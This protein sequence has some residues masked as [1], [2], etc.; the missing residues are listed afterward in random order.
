MRNA[1]KNA[2]QG[3]AARRQECATRGERKALRGR[4]RRTRYVAIS[5]LLWGLLP[6]AHAFEAI[7]DLYWPE[8]GRFPAYPAVTDS[9]TVRFNAYTGVMRDSNVFRLSDTA[10]PVTVLGTGQK[11]DTIFRLG[12]GIDVDLPVSRQ[13]LVLTG[14]VERRDYDQFDL[15]DHTAYQLGGV[16]RWVVGNDWSGDIGYERRK[17]LEGFGEIQAPLKDM[18]TADHAYA[19][20]G[21]LLTPR[22]RVRGGLEW[23]KFDHSHPTQS[24]VDLE[25]SSVV[26]GLDYMTPAMNSIGGQLRYTNGNYPN[27][28]L[29]GVGLVD[30]SYKE[31]ELSAVLHWVLTG[32]T[33]LDARGGYTKREHD[34]FGPQRDFD[35]FTGRASL[36]WFV[37]PKTLLNFA[38]WRETLANT[39]VLGVDLIT[40]TA[41]FTSYVLS[42]GASFGPSWAPTAQLVFQ[43]RIVRETREFKGSGALVG[44]PE[45]EDKFTGLRLGAGWTP[46]RWIELGLAVESGD[47]SSNLVGRDYDY[48]TV[49]ANARVRF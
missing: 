36:D 12:A 49:S 19:N 6:A 9:R 21:Y 1:R 33:T 23:W 20:A 18:V 10:N 40:Q 29:T 5:L 2:A 26:V 30:N 32:K 35:G 15:L 39:G 17:Y 48:T 8:S 27:P 47:R 28:Q 42:T 7:E 38:V 41:S 44:G 25:T 22:W 14:R 4:M 13:R 37:A 11:H 45:V 34:Q 16:W 46:R 3:S 43:A 31:W 24:V